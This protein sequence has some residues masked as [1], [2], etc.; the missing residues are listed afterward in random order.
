MFYERRRAGNGELRID[1]PRQARRLKIFSR[2]MDLFLHHGVL[3]GNVYNYSFKPID[4]EIY[5]AKK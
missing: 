2:E 3:G 5:D 4:V 1:P